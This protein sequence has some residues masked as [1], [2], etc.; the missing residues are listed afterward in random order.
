MTIRNDYDQILNPLTTARIAGKILYED[1]DK[2]RMVATENEAIMDF[3]NG[4]TIGELSDSTWQSVL[5]CV[6]Q[7]MK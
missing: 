1:S 6:E 2:F 7:Y 3:L 4:S 5:Q